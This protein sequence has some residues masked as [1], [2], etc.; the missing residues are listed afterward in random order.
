M[1][2]PATGVYENEDLTIEVEIL[3]VSDAA[4]VSGVM[5]DEQRLQQIEIVK[6]RAT[7][8]YRASK[9][10]EALVLFQEASGHASKLSQHTAETMEHRKILLQN[11]AT[12]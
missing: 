9:F 4:D 5:S 2:D 3:S 10:Q 7:T 1:G 6:E 8:E 12:T 11:I